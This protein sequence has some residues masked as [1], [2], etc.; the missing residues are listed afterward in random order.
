M[1]RTTDTRAG[2]AATQSP[3]AT[4]GGR[5]QFVAGTPA[6]VPRS[7]VCGNTEML[8]GPATPPTGSVRVDPG[9][10]LNML[11]QARPAG[12]TF[13]LTTGT[14]TLGQSEFAQVVPKDG[15][16]YI[17]GP[18]AV[19]HGQGV[20]RYAFTQ[21]AKNVT[22]KHLE[23]TG[24][25]APQNEGVV[26]QSAGTGWT[27]ERNTITGNKG[28]GV[29][30]GSDVTVR[31]NCLDSNGQ[32]GLSGYKPPIGGGSSITNVVVDQNEIS[33]NN[34][35]DWEAKQPQC[36][37]SGGV[38]FW[39]VGAA[40][41]TNNW[42]HHNQ[43]VGLWADTNNIGFLIEGNT[44]EDNH[45]EGLWYEISYNALIRNNTFRRNTLVKGRAYE[46]R[47]DT[48]PIG[49]IYIAE[50]GGDRRVNNGVYSTLEITGNTMENNWGGIVLWEAAER[51]CNSPGNTSAGY[52][53]RVN[54]LVTHQTCASGTI[55]KEP[56]YSDCRWKT[57]NVLVRGNLFKLHKGTI[58]CTT[59]F[60]GRSGLLSG[61]GTAY[62]S[63]SPY[64]G[65]VIQDA[66]TF[67]RN[68][69]F[70]D[71]TYVGDWLFIPYSADKFLIPAVWQASHYEQDAGSVFTGQSKI[72]NYL[73]A[74][75]H[76]L[77]G[78][79]GKW[80]KWYNATIARSTEHAQRGSA[81]LEV[82]IVEAGGWG[83]TLGN[84]PGF[85]VTPGDKTIAFWGR[86]GSGSR[87]GAT[88]TVKWRDASDAVIRTDTVYVRFLDSKW[89]QAR[90]DV[91]APAGTSNAWVEF[92]HEDG[93]AGDSLYLDA[94][95]V[96]DRAG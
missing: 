49:S 53:T 56:Y 70:R 4:T 36:G 96:G 76:S 62:P 39:D 38:K 34:T 95:T 22:I 10:D 75:T 27:I 25:V 28:A 68:N 54:P 63:W 33:R 73:D 8:S 5:S 32:Y 50:S 82:K 44:V 24:F 42:V 46:A 43:G 81:S 66:I 92:A 6:T 65:T 30:L 37:C 79:I 87:I 80:K 20:N 11:T 72:A 7:A 48:F 61:Y 3:G 16:T 45:A 29:F 58:G 31:L 74:D 90:A 26:N 77:E 83:V 71:N 41:I 91:V 78:S 13:Y 86:L 12:T 2:A 47:G 93:V 67:K 57:Q 85:P 18:G 51:F 14:H 59:N 55:N 9:Q 35:D 19:L 40:K 69:V 21:T 89:Q 17:G 15:N 88:M 52:C 94:I 84:Y 23:V 1:G 64:L 60:C